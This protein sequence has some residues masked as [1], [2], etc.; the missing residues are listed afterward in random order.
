MDP[1]KFVLTDQ[2][3]QSFADAMQYQT[4]IENASVFAETEKELRRL[5]IEDAVQEEYKIGPRYPNVFEMTRI[6]DGA[7][8]HR[9]EGVDAT[10]MLFDQNCKGEEAKYV[11]RVQSGRDGVPDFLA[12]AD[13]S[14][15][16]VMHG[17]ARAEK[18]LKFTK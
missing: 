10:L 11:L 4:I 2:A 17:N 18:G 12:V 14:N 9:R 8:T 1:Q 13:A 15:C 5:R 3:L 6:R 7:E 16:V